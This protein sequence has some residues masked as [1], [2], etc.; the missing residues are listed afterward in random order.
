MDSIYNYFKKLNFLKQYYILLIFL[1]TTVIV[2]IIIFSNNN[3]LK[4]VEE[5]INNQIDKLEKCIDLENKN[6]RTISENIKLSEYCIDK[7]GI[8]RRH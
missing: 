8:I 7:F 3:Q 1:I 6:K 2:Q 5:K 4:N